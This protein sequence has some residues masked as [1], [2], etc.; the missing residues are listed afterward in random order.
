MP[1]LHAPHPHVHPDFDEHPWRTL[2]IALVAIVIFAAVLI[3]V[4]FEISKA[5]TGR[6]Y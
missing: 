5:V 1:R 2:P 3:V 4:S 6:A